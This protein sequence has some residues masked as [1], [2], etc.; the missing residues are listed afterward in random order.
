MHAS[1]EKANEQI[2]DRQH[3]HPPGT[4]SDEPGAATFEA[5]PRTTPSSAAPLDPNL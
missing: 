2:E 3:P 4:S 5:T 1:I